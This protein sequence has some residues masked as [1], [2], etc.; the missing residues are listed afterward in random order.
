MPT[1]IEMMA[2]E[3]DRFAN[4]FDAD[5]ADAP[6]RA[7]L[8]ADELTRLVPGIRASAC[9]QLSDEDGPFEH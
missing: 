4:L 3:T 8:D 1:L 6:L 7:A 2:P 5:R 9:G